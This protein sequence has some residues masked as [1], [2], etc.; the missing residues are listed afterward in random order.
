MFLRQFA[1]KDIVSYSF[2][3]FS[4]LF[5]SEPLIHNFNRI[6]Y[7]LQSGLQNEVNFALN[8]CSLLSNVTNSIF[9]LAKVSNDF[10]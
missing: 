6:S 1:S 2:L 4:F 3:Y 5:I 9:N 10:F 7:S 8:I